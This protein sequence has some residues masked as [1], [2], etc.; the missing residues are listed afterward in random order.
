MLISNLTD[1]QP[2]LTLI[3]TVLSVATLGF[4]VSLAKLMSDAAK[5]RAEVM[6]ERLK[7]SEEEARRL[8][9]WTER[10]KAQL[11]LEVDNLREQLSM[12]GVKSTLDANEAIDRIS[13][14]VRDALE[15]RLKE[16]SAAISKQNEDSENPEAALQLGRGYMTTGQWSL[17]AE[18]LQ[19]YLRHNPADFETQFARGLAYMNLRGGF[20]TDLSALRAYNEA[21]AFAPMNRLTRKQSPLGARLFIYR[22]A[23]LKRLGRLE[24]AEK[25]VRIGLA[26]ATDDYERAD[27]IYNLACILALQGDKERLVSTLREARSLRR[28]GYVAK[29]VKAHMADYFKK[30]STDSDVLALLNEFA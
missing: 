29:N 20:D 17:A 2:Y 30:F 19:V 1:L 11:Q 14:D 23:V 8:E 10:E 15:R 22:G 24:E 28:K 26:T 27:G 7:K 3:G 25:D 13:R 9:K 4:V 5:A 21:I 6:E 12:A 18:Y 16:V